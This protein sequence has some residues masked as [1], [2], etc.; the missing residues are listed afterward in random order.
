VARIKLTG[1]SGFDHHFDFAI[2]AS[3]KRPERL[4]RAIN[5][6]SRDNI[7]VL[8][9]AWSDTR[10]VRAPEAQA[11]AL[12]NDTERQ[13]GS[14]ALQALRAYQITPVPWSAREKYVEELVA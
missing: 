10:E 11:L 8:C 7:E 9:F 6:P 12:L 2:P 5:T 4:L 1:R 13:I 3:D 14:E